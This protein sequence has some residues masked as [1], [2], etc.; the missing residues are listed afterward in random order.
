MMKSKR[1]GWVGLV[2]LVGK[3]RNA[4]SVLVRKSEGRRPF[5]RLRPRWEVK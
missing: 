1:M 4:F 5:G 3:F 2:V